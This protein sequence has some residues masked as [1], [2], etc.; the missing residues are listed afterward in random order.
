MMPVAPKNFFFARATTAIAA[1]M[2]DVL[3]V[4]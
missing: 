3:A 4:V 2:R 1:R